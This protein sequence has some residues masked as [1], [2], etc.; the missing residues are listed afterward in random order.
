MSPPCG[1]CGSER[2]D[3]AECPECGAPAGVEPDHLRFG[4]LTWRR[5][6]LPPEE[7]RRRLARRLGAE[8]RLVARWEAAAAAAIAA[9]SPPASLPPPP[10]TEPVP[11]APPGPP[12]FVI[13]AVERPPAL[14]AE[15]GSGLLLANLGWWIGGFLLVAGA[16]FLVGTVWSA[17]PGPLRALVEVGAIAGLAAALTQGGGTLAARGRSAG[18]GLAAVGLALSLVGGVVIGVEGLGA[19]GALA[20][21]LAAA[22][23]AAVARLAS[24]AGITPIPAAAWAVATVLPAVPWLVPALAWPAVGLSLALAAGAVRRALQD[25]RPERS[26]PLLGGAALATAGVVLAALPE[27]GPAV[28]WLL[29]PFVGAVAVWIDAVRTRWRGLDAPAFARPLP[30][31]GAALAVGALAGLLAAAV[32]GGG[33]ALAGGLGG[34][35][36]V[37]T[38]RRRHPSEVTLALTELAGILTVPAAVL[39]ALGARGDGGRAGFL[40]AAALA[41]PVVLRSRPDELG[42]GTLLAAAA[43]AAAGPVEGTWTGVVAGGAWALVAAAVTAASPGPTSTGLACALALGSGAA[44]ALR[45][46]LGAPGLVGVATAGA[47]GADLLAR[48]LR[49]RA[50]GEAHPVAGVIRALEVTSLAAIAVGAAAIGAARAFDPPPRAALAAVALAVAT[51]A[52][53]ARRREELL[54]W[55]LLAPLVVAASLARPLLGLSA[56]PAVALCAAAAGVGAAGALLGARDRAPWRRWGQAAAPSGAAPEGWL[57]GPLWGAALAGSVAVG[58]AAGVE[59]ALGRPGPAAGVA[60]AAA[61][62][63]F[64]AAR[65]DRRPWVAGL[66]AGLLVA[67]TAATAWGAV[68]T[69][70]ALPLAAAAGLAGVAAGTGR[71]LPGPAGRAAALGVS[72]VLVAG[73]VGPMVAGGG[74]GGI[75]AAAVAVGAAAPLFALA[76]AT[77]G[78]AFAGGGCALLAVAVAAA[79]APHVGTPLAWGAVAAGAS[80]AATG[81]AAGLRALGAAPAVR[82][83]L[84]ASGVA[85]ALAASAASTVGVTP[86]GPALL[87]HGAA[88]AAW[89]A[90][91]A[92]L[93]RPS[94]A[95]PF[96]AAGVAVELGWL[97]HL[98]LAPVTAG[99][100]LGA[101]ALSAGIAA[102]VAA[103]RGRGGALAALD[104][105]AAVG[106]QVAGA[107]VALGAVPA[108]LAVSTP[109]A[110]AGLA[111]AAAWGVGATLALD[112]AGPAL[113]TV[114]AAG[115]LG[116]HLQGPLGAA[117]AAALAAWAGAL[118]RGRGDDLADR[119]SARTLVPAALLLAGLAV[120]GGAWRAASLAPVVAVVALGALGPVPAAGRAPIVAL[121]PALVVALAGLGA[122]ATAGAAAA[123][124][125]ALAAW[126]VA[127]GAPWL[128]LAEAAALLAVA[129]DPFGSPWGLAARWLGFAAT[130]AP[131]LRGPHAEPALA[132][133]AGAGAAAGAALAVREVGGWAVA[134][135]GVVVAA[136]WLEAARALRLPL[137]WPAAALGLASLGALGIAPAH[138]P[139]AVAGALLAAGTAAAHEARTA[140]RG[141]ALLAVGTALV[142]AASLRFGAP[143]TVADGLGWIG[144]GGLW[145]GAAEVA[146]RAGR[147]RLAE[148][149]RGAAFLLPGLGITVAAGAPGGLGPAV[150]VAA[151]ASWAAGHARDRDAPSLIAAFLAVDLA[152]VTALARAGAGDPTFHVLPFAVSAAALSQ[153]W[154]TRL[155]AGA[156][157]GIRWGAAGAL[158]AVAIGRLLLT[159]DNVLFGVGIA[160]L[161]LGAG[162]WLQVRAWV[163]SG[164]AFLVVLILVQAARFGVAHQ[165][166]L[167]ALLFVAGLGVLGGTVALSLR[168]SAA[169]PPGRD[170]EGE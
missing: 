145:V 47:L 28:G 141:S 144:L 119:V 98:A 91:R 118:L 1:A 68:G 84:Q 147:P 148:A 9:T 165:L 23:S 159:A 135:W 54:G 90:A 120:A 164:A 57:A 21:A 128:A 140:S 130:I 40:A 153:H 160:L 34:L 151:A 123:G 163:W 74:A 33:A 122:P 66:G 126:S 80:L 31:L 124:A 17:L 75:P 113:A 107:A 41:A 136:G 7:M 143:A 63:G 48:A 67:A 116:A 112:R 105:E 158:Y 149:L 62:L 13:P 72:A 58:G 129:I 49:A 168:R 111:A 167:G 6:D 87:A 170:D 8:L 88:L 60:A 36:L 42:R 52:I 139:G 79:A 97:A 11:A 12:R 25:R 16:V 109:A 155:R 29:A 89:A 83:A 59:A 78:A 131:R 156:L 10:P 64:G 37:A 142:A 152:I 81:A 53:G 134:P 22:G 26:A 92:A 125:L 101:V 93:G 20:A 70:A 104:P 169:E 15:T 103:V 95:G 115:A 73:L 102:A 137:R 44:A 71:G 51:F 99:L 132:T 121:A 161:G 30:V 39:G 114:V 55:A 32:F 100:D 157:E 3:A 162:A 96:V 19:S 38:L 106:A 24:R 5:G 117:T 56:D 4:A 82:G 2:V 45:L 46:G 86:D 146:L 61:G 14:P 138:R 35:A 85:A 154:R 50:P 127:T 94:A 133:L 150:F 166:G 43:L 77:G 65:L 110:T 69:A 76:N 27:T 108:L 18:R